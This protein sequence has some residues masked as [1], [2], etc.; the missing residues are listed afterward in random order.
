MAGNQ[1]ARPHAPEKSTGIKLLHHVPMTEHGATGSAG[2][3][4]A[5][6]MRQLRALADEL[7]DAGALYGT[8]FYI[9]GLR[10][11]GV[12]SE[13]CA[14]RKLAD[15]SYEVW[16]S[17]SGVRQTVLRT[18]DFQEACSVLREEVLALAAEL[19]R[20]QSGGK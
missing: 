18:T 1:C 11:M 20:R 17:D 10:P 3:T 4:T 9:E 8:D 2:G 19:Q 15:G 5:D 12:S 7:C 13:Y 16:Y 14:L 6:E